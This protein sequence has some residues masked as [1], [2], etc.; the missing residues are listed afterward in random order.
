MRGAWEKFPNNLL[1][2]FPKDAMEQIVLI[3]NTWIWIINIVEAL[4]ELSLGN[5]NTNTGIN[6]K[7]IIINILLSYKLQI[8]MILQS[9]STQKAF[10][11]LPKEKKGKVC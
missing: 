8:L 9:L 7:Q 10:D 1:G 4:E 5:R 6:S 11:H 3:K 2:V